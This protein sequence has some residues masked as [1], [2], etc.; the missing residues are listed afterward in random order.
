MKDRTNRILLGVG[1][2]SLALCSAGFIVDIRLLLFLPAIPAFCAPALLFRLTPSLP[3]RLIP[4]ILLALFAGVGGLILLL[5][6][7]WD[8]L[9]GLL[10]LFGSIAPAVGLAAAFLCWL[11]SRK[12]GGFRHG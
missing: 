7:G 5:A 2:L 1:L 9:L 8:G 6:S 4:L 3:L 11:F 10:M 12:K